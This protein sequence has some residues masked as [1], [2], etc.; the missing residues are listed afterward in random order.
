MSDRIPKIIDPIHLAEKRRFFDGELPL[1]VMTRLSTKIENLDD[2]VFFQLDF[3][4]IGKLAVTKGSI[5]AKIQMQCQ[6]CLQLLEIAVDSD[7]NLAVVQSEEQAAL[8]PEAY[9]AL[10]C[11]QENMVFEDIIE[12]EI[13]LALPVIPKHQH[14]CFERQQTDLTIDSKG[15]STKDS[16]FSVLATLK[17]LEH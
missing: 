17:K 2:S 1:S 10:L 9:E 15:Q 6:S 3:T 12:D 13:L 8:L 4:K 11:E 5:R 16:P 7:V 14:R